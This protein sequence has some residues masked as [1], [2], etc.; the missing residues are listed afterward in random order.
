MRLR[1]S[2]VLAGGDGH[3]VVRMTRRGDDPEAVGAAVA[4]ALVEGG[5][6]AIDGFD[7]LL[8]ALP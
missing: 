6:A 4:R 2:G 8:D 7:G 1:V 5:A 3:V